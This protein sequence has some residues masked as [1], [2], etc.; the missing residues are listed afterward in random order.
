MALP[1]E[2]H[3]GTL[4]EKVTVRALNDEKNDIE[5]KISTESS[6]RKKGLAIGAGAT[7]LGGAIAGIGVL[8]GQNTFSLMSVGGTLTFAGLPHL[9]DS[10]GNSRELNEL[11]DRK[12]EI[13]AVTSETYFFEDDQDFSELLEES[14]DLEFED[15]HYPDSSLYEFDEEPAESFYESLMGEPLDI[16]QILTVG[17]DD[18]YLLE[19]EVR[20]DEEES[21]EL[22]GRF[23]GEAE[24]VNEYLEGGRPAEE[25]L[26]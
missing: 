4:G 13:E 6:E 15:F 25:V 10:R 26:S 3:E 9:A 22:A 1:E 21:Y 5:N 12:D 24:D 18:Q 17:E 8:A 23:T 11:R 14:T 7:G 20:E 2:Y 19:V 16:N